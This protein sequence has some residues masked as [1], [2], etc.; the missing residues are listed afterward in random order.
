VAANLQDM[1]K[2]Q[3]R[4]AT[5]KALGVSILAIL[6]V[7]M[8]TFGSQAEDETRFLRI[9]TGSPGGTYFPIGNVIADALTGPLE[10]EEC[11]GLG[12][13]GIPGLM[14]VARASFGAVENLANI[15]AGLVETGF[16]QSDLAY[17]ATHGKALY[18]EDGPVTEYRAI[19]SLYPEVLHIVVP[20]TSDIEKPSD[21]RGKRVS[22]GPKGSGTLIDAQLVLE[23]YGLE[24]QDVRARHLTFEGAAEALK[25][26]DIDAFF[27]IGGVPI[28]AIANLSEVY[29]IRVLALDDWAIAELTDGHPFFS[30]EPVD[31]T[32]YGLPKI[33]SVAV[34]ALWLTTDRVPDDVVYEITK[35]LW[36]ETTRQALAEA[37]PTGAQLAEASSSQCV[38]IPLHPGAERYYKEH[39]ALCTNARRDDQVTN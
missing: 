17:W 39:G 36:L 20:A 37:H 5:Q 34:Q 4:Q 29:P 19:A 9:G 25:V 23:I 15:R 6:L 8:L 13:C 3:L 10:D 2:N 30:H 27:A 21:L 26:G 38:A 32:P 33:D 1:Q 22:L 16:V 12:P 35:A 31:M 11:S 28:P 7:V 24:Q 14:A 18:E